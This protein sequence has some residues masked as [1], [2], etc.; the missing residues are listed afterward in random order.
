MTPGGGAIM[1]PDQIASQSRQF[2][3]DAA[4]DEYASDDVAIDD[5]ATIST[6]TAP[7]GR[8][9]GVWVQA[10]V[11]VAV[12]MPLD[13]PA[14]AAPEAPTSPAAPRNPPRPYQE[15]AGAKEAPR[16]AS[17]R[18]VALRFC[19]YEESP[20][21][22]RVVGTP[23]DDPRLVAAIARGGYDVRQTVT[24]WQGVVD[25]RVHPFTHIIR[26]AGGAHALA[27]LEDAP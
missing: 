11:R 24:G 17:P 14:K 16:S 10:W 8:L 5:D 1:R 12:D 27:R 3:L 4:R 13:L 7:D 22:C 18:V 9:L 20:F 19:Q 23:I 21:R 26:F 6:A 25:G 2:W 15:G